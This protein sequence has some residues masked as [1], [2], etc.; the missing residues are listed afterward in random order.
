MAKNRFAKALS[1]F[2]HSF[3]APT[4]E[5]AEERYLEGSASIYDLERRMQEIDRGKF[6][7][8]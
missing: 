1:R 5:R 8:F 3:N 6:R 2:A 4:R 7:N